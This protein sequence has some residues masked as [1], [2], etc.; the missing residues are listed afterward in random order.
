MRQARVHHAARRCSGVFRFVAARRVRATS[1]AADHRGLGRGH[2]FGLDRLDRRFCA[3]TWRTRLE[4]GTH[5]CHRVSLGGRAQRALSRN[6][7]RVRPAQGRCHRHGGRR[8]PCREPGHIGHSHRFRDCYR[9][10]W[11]RAGRV[12]WRGPAATSPACRCRRLNLPPS[13][14]NYCARCCPVFAS[15]RSSAMSTTLPRWWRW[16]RFCPPPACLASTS[17]G[18]KSGVPRISRPPSPGSRSVHRRSTCVATRC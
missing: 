1:Q 8:S 7:S 5:G 14:S 4:R 15:W 17:I 11:D 9:P 2:A 3:A 12:I 10:A 16:A 6:C 13:G 18:S